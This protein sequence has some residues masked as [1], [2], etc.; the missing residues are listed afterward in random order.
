LK[1]SKGWEEFSPGVFEG[2]FFKEGKT[3][4]PKVSL[5]DSSSN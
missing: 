5:S 1:F 2:N 3:P 4:R